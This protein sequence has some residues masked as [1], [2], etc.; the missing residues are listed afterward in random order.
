MLK[1]G[2]DIFYYYES[3]WNTSSFIMNNLDKKIGYLIKY[4]VI[5]ELIK[6]KDYLSKQNRLSQKKNL[7]NYHNK[8]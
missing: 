6:Q 5:S 7:I 1:N 4:F 2:I 8:I 3:I